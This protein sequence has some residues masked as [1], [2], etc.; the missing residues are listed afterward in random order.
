MMCNAIQ[1]LVHDSS[2]YVMFLECVLVNHACMRQIIIDCRLKS[3]K[4]KKRI[5]LVSI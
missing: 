1:S 2:S 5:P 4:D 3:L